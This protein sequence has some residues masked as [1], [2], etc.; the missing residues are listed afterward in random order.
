MLSMRGAPGPH[1]HTACAG[2]RCS[3]PHPYLPIEHSERAQLL[4]AHRA[5]GL[6]AVGQPRV[7]GGLVH[8]PGLHHVDGG[9][10]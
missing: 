7:G 9:F 1:T 10:R 2:A 8:V 4:Q 3:S 5:V 6:R